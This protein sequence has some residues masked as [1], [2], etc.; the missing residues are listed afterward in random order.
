MQYLR[1][2]VEKKKQYLIGL[3]VKAGVSK[4]TD[5]LQTLTLTELENLSRKHM[6]LK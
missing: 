2:A 3:L 6:I 4:E 1:K 5:Q